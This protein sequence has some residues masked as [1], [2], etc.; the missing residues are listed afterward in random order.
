MSEARAIGA[1]AASDEQGASSAAPAKV[2]GYVILVIALTFMCNVFLGEETRAFSLGLPLIIKE[3][4]VTPAQI[5]LIQTIGYWVG[6]IG[7]ISVPIIADAWGRR[8]AFLTVLLLYSI[9]A[10][11]IGL[12]QTFMQ[13]AVLQALAQVPRNTGTI[14][15]MVLAESV[16]TRVR[17]FFLSF[18][19]SSV[20][21][22]YSVSALLAGVLIPMWGWRSM[23]FIE[24]SCFVLFAVAFWKLR[25]T[26]G[27]RAAQASRAREGKRQRPD[28]LLP[29]KIYPG[30]A[31]LAFVILTLYLLAY[32]GFSAW[33]TAWLV[34][35]LKI[36]YVRSTHWIAIWL[37]VSTLSYW[38]CGWLANRFGKKKIIPIFAVL[39]GGCMVAVIVHRWE[40]DTIFWIGLAMN[41]FIT[42]HYGSGS[43]AYVTE[44][45]PAQI[46]GSVQGSFALFVGLAASWA[47][48]IPP[49]LAGNDLTH[50]SRGFS[51]AAGI[52]FVLAFIFLF[53]APET[54]GKPLED[55]V[56]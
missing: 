13:L 32:P 14:N 17:V 3:F 38:I 40:P 48:T 7:M 6:M 27:F 46:R 37:G 29:W 5:G 42:A 21:L 31:T 33:Q 30:R 4:G 19:N 47:P 55:V 24:A 50:I 53:I 25:E 18:L 16:P 1:V 22:A 52:M 49:L 9:L 44:L 23:F 26:P 20:P 45:F 43:F 51:F 39:G 15:Y 34:N 12:A 56:A 2:T 54:A 8:I 28:L 35:E 41:F 36:E 11:L 10:P